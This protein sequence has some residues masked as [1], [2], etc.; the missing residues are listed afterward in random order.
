MQRLFQSQEIHNVSTL[1]QVLPERIP[2][3]DFTG[4]PAQS[5]RDLRRSLLDV[6]PLF[7]DLGCEIGELWEFYV[8]RVGCPSFYLHCDPGVRLNFDNAFARRLG[9]SN[10]PPCFRTPTCLP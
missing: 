7:D 5:G 4:F 6:S 2:L 3:S 10:P 1:R 9:I 8:V